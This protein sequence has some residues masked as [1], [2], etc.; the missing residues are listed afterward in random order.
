M[1]S[2]FVNKNYIDWDEYLLYVMMVYRLIIYEIIGFLLNLLM[3]GREVC[4]FLDIM[5]DV[6]FVIKLVF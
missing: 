4:I 5:Y 6:F 2:N 3:F 1:F